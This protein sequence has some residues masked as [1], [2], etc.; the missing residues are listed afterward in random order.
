MALWS[1]PVDFMPQPSESFFATI[2]ELLGTI[3]AK[4][5][6]KLHPSD[7][8]ELVSLQANAIKSV[9]G[10][11]VL[12]GSYEMIVQ[13]LNTIYDFTEKATEDNVNAVFALCKPVLESYLEQITAVT[14]T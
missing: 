3:A 4:E 13:A 9:F 8:S 11:A 1:E 2:Q 5:L 6:D 7:R 12:S 14:N 10:V